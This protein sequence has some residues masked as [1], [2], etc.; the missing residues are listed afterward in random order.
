ASQNFRR[1]GVCED[2]P[3]LGWHPFRNPKNKQV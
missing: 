2:W 1:I 3:S